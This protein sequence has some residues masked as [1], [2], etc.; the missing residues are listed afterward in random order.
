MNVKQNNHPNSS[1]INKNI[2]MLSIALAIILTTTLMVNPTVMVNLNEVR[3]QSA[4][5]SMNTNNNKIIMHFHPHLNTI[6]F[7]TEKS[8]LFSSLDN[9]ESN[10][11]GHNK[12]DECSKE[13]NGKEETTNQVF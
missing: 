6:K 4:G 13:A 8:K 9:R 10:D 12:N 11:S 3:A 1:N 5:S 7:V 2:E